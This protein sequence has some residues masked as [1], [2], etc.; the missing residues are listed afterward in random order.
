MER[1]GTFIVPFMMNLICRT[2]K[3][4][5]IDEDKANRNT[6]NHIFMFWH[7][8]MLVP[9]FINRNK[10]C[11]A[12]V[13]KSSDGE[14]LAK[15]LEKWNYK[16]IRGSSSKDSKEVMQNMTSA[17]E[18]GESLAITP[19][20][21]RGPIHKLKIGSLIAAVRSGSKIILCGTAYSKKIIMKSWDRF[22]IP[23]PFSK[24][25]LV[26]S[27]PKFFAEG[28]SRSDYDKI[29]YELENELNSLQSQAQIY[30]AKKSLIA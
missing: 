8:T 16:L 12:V 29:N 4:K 9:W 15:L 7:G 23:K 13:S 3:I 27:K 26:L 10:N 24:A 20:G 6:S 5:I 18:S 2:L 17:L 1:L 19:D 28:L 21:P 14:I 30:L 25:V 11:T 22:E